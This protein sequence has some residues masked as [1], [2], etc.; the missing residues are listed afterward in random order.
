M[1]IENKLTLRH[2]KINKRR[3][4]ITVLG[5]I[6]SVAM[7]T[8]LFVSISSFLKFY[9]EVTKYVD[10]SSVMRVYNVTDEQ[11]ESF[12]K[13]QN[14]KDV[15]ICIKDKSYKVGDYNDNFFA[16]DSAALDMLITA[17]YEGSLPKTGGEIMAEKKFISRCGLQWKIGDTVTLDTG[18]ISG[19][20]AGFESDG[21]KQYK[22]VGILDGNLPTRG[23]SVIRNIDADESGA[24]TAEITL[25]QLNS[26]SYS[27]IKSIL[28]EAGI[29]EDL[30]NCSISRDLLLAAGDA[31]ASSHLL[32]LLPF[33]IILIAIIGAA[34]V[35][36][37]YNAF[38]MSLS[39]RTRY[40]GMLASVGATKAQKRRSVY[41]EGFILGIIGIPLGIGFGIL[42]I[43]ITLKIV[44]KRISETGMIAG[45]TNISFNTSIPVW[46]IFAIIAVA[47]LT[48]I[49]SSIIPAVRASRVSPIDAIRQSNQIKLKAKKLRSSKLI[50]LIFGYEGELAN[51]NLKRNGAKGRVIT[52]SI[53]LSVI[54]FLIV[55]FFCA[56][57]TNEI[58][59]FDNHFQFGVGTFSAKAHEDIINTLKS[60]KSIDNYISVSKNQFEFHNIEE[61]KS[62]IPDLA[63]KTLLAKSNKNYYNKKSLLSVIFADDEAF[64]ELCRYNKLDSEDYIG[65]D[66]CLLI[67]S[68]DQVSGKP[69]Y[70]KNVLGKNIPVTAFSS[71]ENE[72]YNLSIKAFAECEKDTVL[73]YT[74]SAKGVNVIVP[75]STY[76]S[77]EKDNSFF[78]TYILTGNHDETEEELEKLLSDKDYEHSFMDY[79]ENLQSINSTV[80]IMKVFIYGFIVLITLITTANIM[81]TISTGM[82]LRSREFA[83][84]KSV[85]TTPKGIRKMILLESLFYGLKALVFALPISVL[86]TF[87]MSKVVEAD[88]MPFFI[89][90]K[91]YIMAVI[92]VFIIV[93]VS[94]LMGVSK[95]KRMTIIDALKEDI[96]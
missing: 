68:A 5:I 8:G 11:I 14:V 85:G 34:S 82:D 38:A 40:L 60:A 75:L 28:S 43:H 58:G 26:H 3:S 23:Y 15:G 59:D 31:S 55:N 56:G 30:E 17:E 57:L 65:K 7:I 86:I 96:S 1:K 74:L 93:G 92:A 77:H 66:A 53:A 73:Y 2:L 88:E 19:E 12:R 4:I 48:I 9:G 76:I 84:I 41:F 61:L 67:N 51:K 91:L 6:V 21:E 94:M 20:E 49:I 22:L 35:M 24:R 37:I 95:L 87:I 89:D 36:L 27:T 32:D 79:V 47:A 50:R 72:E 10:G 81:N 70:N 29:E 42:G 45:V 90:W 16:A 25:T 54:V 64:R 80:F 33:V 46:V 63:D 69:A 44:G 52:A 78:V 62:M 83:M 71:E 39:E 13:N 18:R